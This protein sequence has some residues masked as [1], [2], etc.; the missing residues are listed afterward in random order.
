MTTTTSTTTASTSTTTAAYNPASIVQTLGAGS[1]VDIT[2]LVASLVTA[3]Y[4][5]KDSQLADQQTTLT[6]QISGVAAVKSGVTGFSTA[7]NTL[8]TG[9][10]LSTQPNSSNTSVL[11]ATGLSGSKLAGLS[12][13]VVVNQLASA[14]AATTNTAVDPAAAFRTGTFSLQFGSES[15]DSSGTTTFTAGSSSPVSITIGSGDATLSGIAAQINAANAG[16]TASVIGDGNGQRLS[17]KGATGASQAFTLT[18][19]DTDPTADGLSLST[20]SV[21]RQATGTTIGTSAQDA[22]VQLDGATF[23]RASNTISNLISGV[24]LKLVSASTTPVTLGT[25]SPTTALGAAVSDIVDTYNQVLATLQAQTDPVTGVLKSDPSVTALQ[26]ALSILTTTKLSTPSSAGGPSTLAELGVG[27]NKDGTLT[28]DQTALATALNNYPTDVESMFALGTG[29][30]STGNGLSAALAAIATQATDPTYG[31]D[32][33]TANYTKQQSTVT[34]Q[35]SDET[36]AEAAT[37]TQLTQQYA[38]MDSKIA[39]YKS[40]QTFLTA[41]IA[42]WNKSS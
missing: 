16:V 21:G 37:K 30:G 35:Q 29:S 27:T 28:L 23:H 2:S 36:T 22:I 17:I 39:A 3:Q 32:V 5:A 19:T 31:L 8:V 7:F 18:G 15:T 40:T 26:R 12:A 6:A 9:G 10:T 33:S 25:D 38:A 42:A 13:T 24:Q 11:T 34:D 1:G 41:Q 20:L 4:Q 14:Q